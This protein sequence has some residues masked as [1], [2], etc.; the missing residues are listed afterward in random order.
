M[1]RDGGLTLGVGVSLPPA[2]LEKGGRGGFGGKAMM[3]VCREERRKSTIENKL[4][5]PP[6]NRNYMKRMCM[7]GP[8]SIMPLLFSL[9]LLLFFSFEQGLIPPFKQKGR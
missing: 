7:G 2:R 5:K 6:T 3:E 4:T 8:L 9:F 1:S